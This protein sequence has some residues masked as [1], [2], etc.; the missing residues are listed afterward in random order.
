MEIQ[1]FFTFPFVHENAYQK[2][3]SQFSFK[4]VAS[5]FFDLTFNIGL[6][7]PAHRKELED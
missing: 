7:F 3:P 1:W 2:V 6:P 5:S 4:A